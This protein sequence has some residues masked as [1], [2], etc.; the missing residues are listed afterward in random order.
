MCLCVWR[1]CLSALFRCI[2]HRC[3]AFLSKVFSY[4]MSTPLKLTANPSM[5]SD[6]DS[7]YNFVP[8]FHSV[9]NSINELLVHDIQPK[10]K[11]LN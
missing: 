5:L 10:M 2:Y 6:H 4:E 3:M 8:T 7:C 1:V 11:S 9:S